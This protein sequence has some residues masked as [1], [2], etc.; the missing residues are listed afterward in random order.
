[1]KRYITAFLLLLSG[2]NFAAA[3][4][5]EFINI[6]E[7]TDRDGASLGR[8]QVRYITKEIFDSIRIVK[9]IGQREELLYRIDE[10]RFY[11]RDALE[12]E[13]YDPGFY[14]YK[15]TS[16]A[17]DQVVLTYMR[18]RGKYASDNITIKWDADSNAFHKRW[19]H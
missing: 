18:N 5:E 8:L 2:I 7:F 13:V 11:S 19:Q 3:E 17:P 4:S 16:M 9:R 1:M 15:I 6:H 12:Q 14:G 10:S